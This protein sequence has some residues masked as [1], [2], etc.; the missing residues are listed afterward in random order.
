LCERN[1][2]FVYIYFFNTKHGFFWVDPGLELRRVLEKIE[3]VKARG[4]PADP[5]DWPGDPVKPNQKL[6]CNLLIF[7]FFIKTT[8]FWF[9]SKNQNWPGWSGQNSKPEFI[10]T[11]MFWFFS[12]NQNWPGWS[13]QNSKPE[14]WT[15]LITG[16]V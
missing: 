6:G 1:L 9:F 12:K 8:M 2:L 4:D 3:E 13:G 14:S 16:S 11:T 5:E 7:V 15:G 10:K